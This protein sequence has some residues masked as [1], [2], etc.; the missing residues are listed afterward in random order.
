MKNLW[1]SPDLP[2]A[3]PR[4]VVYRNRF[5]AER[6]QELVFDFS[7]DEC[8]RLFLNGERVADGP[9]RGDARHWYFS[10]FR[11]AL[12]PGDYCLTARVLCFGSEL[13]AHAQ[14][15][16][17][18]GL[19]VKEYSSLL[20]SWEY[21]FEEGLA[22]RKPYPD[23]GVYPRFD[24]DG[25][26]PEILS[27]RGGVWRGVAF[28]EDSRELHEPELPPMRYEPELAYHRIGNRFYFDDYVCVWTDYVFSGE[29][30]VKIRWGENLYDTP[31]LN[32]RLQGDKGKRDGGFL[33]S[34]CNTLKL[35]GGCFRWVDYHWHALRCLEIECS[36]SV[37]PEEVH[38]HRTGYP[39]RRE[40]SAHSSLPALNRLLETAYRTLEACSHETFM[41]CPY[42]EQLMYIGDARLEALSVYVTSTDARL[43]GKALRML[44]RSQQADGLIFSRYPARVDQVIPSFAMIWI[45]MLH[46]YALWQDDPGTVYEL[47]PCARRIADYLELHLKD[48]LLY[49]PGWNFIDWVDSWPHGEPAG[50]ENDGTNSILNLFAVIA[51]RQL[52]GLEKYAG[53]EEHGRRS[54]MLADRI[55]ESVR[56]HYW[57]EARGLYANDFARK[58]YSE[59]AQSLA[60]IIEPDSR[61]AET[62]SHVSGLAECS[63]Y[64]SFYYLDACYRNQLA[65]LFFKRLERYFDL[66]KEGLRTLPEEF[67]NPRSDCHAW[68]SHVLYHYFASILGIRPTAF[69]RRKIEIRPM[70]GPLYFAEGKSPVLP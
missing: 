46:D 27:G 10:R 38:F 29:G 59:H 58:Y 15:S 35:S 37:V 22:F 25:C 65:G 47:L 42:Y 54:A 50:C 28:F 55:L 33:N 6:E 2:W 43:A 4:I 17:R 39:F 13:T 69:G 70:K 36:G 30:C 26:N 32:R 11:L 68:S 31:G 16:V 18:H 52:A 41:D 24:A 12:A 51:L 5:K 8:C 1:M 23:W 48:N 49:F 3:P 60:L 57:D 61:L 66:E 40:W 67:R 44:A 53:T 7:A 34:T 20:G 64:F 9:E 14:M 63:I 21:Q 19:F 45:S 56:R 62:F